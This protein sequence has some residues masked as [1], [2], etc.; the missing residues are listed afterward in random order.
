MKLYTF[1]KTSWHVRFFEWLF[2]VNPVHRYKT[3][4]PYFW[5]YVVVFLT[6]PLILLVKMFG[7]G[8]TRFLNYLKDYKENRRLKMVAYLKSLCEKED[9]T[10]EEAYKIWRSRCWKKHKWD[11]ENYYEIRDKLCDL[12]E[13]H[14][15]FMDKMR[16][17][18]YQKRLAQQEVRAQKL[19]EYK[20]AKWF[21]PVSYIIS[22]GL[23]GMILYAIV[24]G[25]YQASIA[26]N[27]A[28]VGH[29]A[30]IILIVLGAIAAFIGTLYA[31]IKFIFIPFFQWL[32]CVKLPECGICNNV[33]AFFRLFIYI[34]MPIKYIVLGM[35]KFVAIIGNMI[36]STYKKQ[37]P[38]ITWED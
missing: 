15:K 5:T 35:I 10:P 29:W 28:V 36:Y 2:G 13:K 4:C 27:W 8:G 22:A 21:T 33:K 18:D 7:K 37:C 14:V 17:A 19:Q 24:F 16:Q 3:M 25:L 12:Y 26:I 30:L 11:L 34:W 6:L 38:V 23:I 1:K 20:E 9:M 32:S 31:L